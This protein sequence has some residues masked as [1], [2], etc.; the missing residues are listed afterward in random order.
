MLCRW[1]P[2]PSGRV[3]PASPTMDWAMQTDPNQASGGWG[4][5]RRLLTLAAA[6]GTLGPATDAIHNQVLLAYDVMPVQLPVLGFVAKTS[7]II[8]PLLAITYCL[9]GGI[10]PPLVAAVLGTGRLPSSLV[11]SLPPER[12]ALLAV[13]ST[14]TI[15][16]ISALLATSNVP[17]SFALGALC[18]LALMQWAVIDG[19]FASLAL[20]VLLAVAGPLAEIPFMALGCWHYTA[21]D[22]WPLATIGFGAETGNPWAGLSSLTGKVWHRLALRPAQLLLASLVSPQ[23]P[24]S[25]QIAL[26]Y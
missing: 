15:I 4:R 8:P 22:Y 1:G 12:R 23:R 11:G 7:L 14:A 2:Y 24:A 19:S 18:S 21:P 25:P 13:A 3:R 16:K 9:L 17:A 26:E 10:F 5:S 20:A 6:G